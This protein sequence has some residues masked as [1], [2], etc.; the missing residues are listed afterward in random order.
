MASPKNKAFICN[1]KAAVR[2]VSP[3]SVRRTGP[4]ERFDVPSFMIQC[5]GT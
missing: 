3:L 2:G 1:Q 4:R 5:M